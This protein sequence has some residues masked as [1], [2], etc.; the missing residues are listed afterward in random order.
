MKRQEQRDRKAIRSK[1]RRFLC[2]KSCGMGFDRKCKLEYHV[3]KGKA[4]GTGC[5]QCELCQNYVTNIIFSVLRLSSCSEMLQRTD[6]Y[7]RVAK[8]GIDYMTEHIDMEHHE[9]LKAQRRNK[10]KEKSLI[11]PMR[12]VLTTWYNIL[13]ASQSIIYDR[14]SVHTFKL[15]VMVPSVLVLVIF[16]ASI[17]IQYSSIRCNWSPEM[18]FN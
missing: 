1:N 12:V 9:V 2:P 3:G 16:P 6:P 8:T 13:N 10:Y 14:T 7:V 17:N 11:N 18:Y 15:L 5:K 4:K